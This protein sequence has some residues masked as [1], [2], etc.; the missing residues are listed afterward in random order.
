MIYHLPLLQV[1]ID[2]HG[3]NMFTPGKKSI[4][5]KIHRTIFH[6]FWNKTDG[7]PDNFSTIFTNEE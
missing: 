1:Y 5:K 4:D 2:V 6:Q 7:L 3:E